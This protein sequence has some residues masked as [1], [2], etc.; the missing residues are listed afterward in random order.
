MISL[1]GRGR[2][3]CAEKRLQLHEL[4]AAQTQRLGLVVANHGI[5]RRIVMLQHLTEGRDLAGAWPG[6]RFVATEG[7]GHLRLLRDPQVIASAVGFLSSDSLRDV[8]AATGSLARPA[9]GVRA[10]A[11][12]RSNGGTYDAAVPRDGLT[13][14][15]RIL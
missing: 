4:P 10:L 8:P 14:R 1:L 6:A 13:W 2:R 11:A 15:V 5:L 3:Q 9:G 12:R 7:L